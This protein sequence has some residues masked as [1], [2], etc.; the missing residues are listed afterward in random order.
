MWEWEGSEEKNG[1]AVGC[2][3]GRNVLCAQRVRLNVTCISF[4]LCVAF[5]IPSHVA[6]FPTFSLLSS[7]KDHSF[8]LIL[9][10]LASSST[11][12]QSHRRGVVQRNQP[13]LFP[14]TCWHSAASSY[15]SNGV[16][17]MQ[18][19]QSLLPSTTSP[20]IMTSNN[21]SGNDIDYDAFQ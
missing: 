10:V 3:C 12:G 11:L 2:V 14:T 4:W 18:Q 9:A 13:P 1:A 17:D 20:Q 16:L 5:A 15:T 8:F 19:D 7:P 21:S 6:F